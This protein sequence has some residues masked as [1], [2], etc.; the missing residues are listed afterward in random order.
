M[1]PTNGQMQDSVLVEDDATGGT[2]T[3]RQAS[4]QVTS[5]AQTSG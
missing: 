2:E 1:R 4:G 5:D 3:S